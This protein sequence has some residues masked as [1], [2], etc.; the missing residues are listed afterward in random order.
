MERLL[1]Q[2]FGRSLQQLSANN[3]A[4]ALPLAV[5]SFL[6]PQ[7]RQTHRDSRA[8]LQGFF[9]G[10]RAISFPETWGVSTSLPRA[11]EVYH[12]S[13]QGTICPVLYEILVLHHNPVGHSLRQHSTLHTHTKFNLSLWQPVPPLPAS[14]TSSSTI[15]RPPTPHRPELHRGSRSS[16]LTLR[17]SAV[18]LP[19]FA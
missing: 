19:N 10:S 16:L 14:P 3:D 12:T 17:R 13:S 7:S 6:G 4:E 8:Y 15:C 5:Q 2:T 1:T 9:S 18:P 11:P